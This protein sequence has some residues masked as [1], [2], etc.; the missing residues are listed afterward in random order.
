MKYAICIAALGMISAAGGDS[1]ISASEVIKDRYDVVV[2]GVVDPTL[3]DLV[4]ID[5][6]ATT[7]VTKMHL[8]SVRPYRFLP[9][10]S[11]RYYWSFNYPAYLSEQLHAEITKQGGDFTTKPRFWGIRRTLVFGDI[12]EPI[13]T[14]WD[15]DMKRLES[16]ISK[17]F[18]DPTRVRPLDLSPLKE[19]VSLSFNRAG[20]I[21]FTNQSEFSVWLHEVSGEYLSTGKSDFCY[22]ITGLQDGKWMNFFYGLSGP[23]GEAYEKFNLSRRIRPGESVSWHRKLPDEKGYEGF[24][25]E[26]TVYPDESRNNGIEITSNKVTRQ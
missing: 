11:P 7:L 10:I 9:D 21:K 16:A 5:H 25:V 26:V 15:E 18:E 14:K 4:T 12:A 1:P 2:Y 17:D 3:K 24:R 13:S 22:Y 23:S 20:E 19:K 8:I 6:S